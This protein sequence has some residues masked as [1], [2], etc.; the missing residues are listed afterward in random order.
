MEIYIVFKP[1]EHGAPQPNAMKASNVRQPGVWPKI[2]H[3][4]RW[5]PTWIVSE[6]IDSVLDDGQDVV[7]HPTHVSWEKEPVLNN[8]QHMANHMEAF[9]AAV[10][11]Y[12]GD[13]DMEDLAHLIT[14]ASMLYATYAKWMREQNCVPGRGHFFGVG[15]TTCQCG[16]QGRLVAPGKGLV[17]RWKWTLE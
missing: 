13:V 7:K 2:M 15:R 9:Y 12:Y 14:R 5:E 3:L 1:D 8:L 16:T 17:E 10:Q 11:G 6:V 4:P